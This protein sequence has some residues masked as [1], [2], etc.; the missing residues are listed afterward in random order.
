MLS[1]VFESTDYTRFYKNEKK[2]TPHFNSFLNINTTNAKGTRITRPGLYNPLTLG[3]S[4]T[5][6]NFDKELE[7]TG[8]QPI[9]SM[10]NDGNVKLRPPALQMTGLRRI[11]TAGS[12]H[13]ETNEEHLGHFDQNTNYGMFNLFKDVKDNISRDK[14][15]NVYVGEMERADALRF[16]GNNV[17]ADKVMEKANRELILSHPLLANIFIN[18]SFFKVDVDSMIN[19]T[20][21]SYG[22]AEVDNMKNLQKYIDFEKN[23]LIKLMMSPDASIEEVNSK[24]KFISIM[25]RLNEIKDSDDMVQLSNEFTENLEDFEKYVNE[26][27]LKTARDVINLS[28]E[29]TVEPQGRSK[30]DILDESEKPFMKE[31]DDEVSKE[32]SGFM[33]KKDKDDDDEKAVDELAKKI[34]NLQNIK[35]DTPLKDINL[36]ALNILRSLDTDAKILYVKNNLKLSLGDVR[37]LADDPTKGGSKNYVRAMLDAL[38]WAKNDLDSQDYIALVKHFQKEAG[39]TLK[40]ESSVIDYMKENYKVNI[41]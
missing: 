28:S 36:K 23:S 20:K 29:Y 30:E 8:P 6:L 32:D 1:D 14:A 34:S 9:E 18:S 21:S 12:Y 41:K 7:N 37:N 26:V 27:S 10:F 4:T 38:D 40:S 25:T 16:N 39:K 3:D 17:Q 22:K 15:L 33:T 24:I 5:F 2:T 13:F 19:R 11:N 35:K 31:V